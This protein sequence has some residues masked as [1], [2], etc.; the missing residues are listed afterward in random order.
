MTKPR[1]HQLSFTYEEM[2]LMEFAVQDIHRHLEAMESIG[3]FAALW[4]RETV[5]ERIKYAEKVE[6]KADD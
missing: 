3:V 1:N 4:L 2:E 6:E 5:L